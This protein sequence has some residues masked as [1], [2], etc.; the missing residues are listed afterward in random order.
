MNIVIGRHLIPRYDQKP[1]GYR[2]RGRHR[3]GHD[4]WTYPE[5]VMTNQTEKTATL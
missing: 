4:Q 5:V 1:D 2:V 3:N